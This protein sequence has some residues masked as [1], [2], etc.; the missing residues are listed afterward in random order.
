MTDEIRLRVADVAPRQHI[1][2]P[3][4]EN[5]EVVGNISGVIQVNPNLSTFFIHTGILGFEY[6]EGQFAG[7]DESRLAQV[8]S[9]LPYGVGDRFGVH[10]DGLVQDWG[11]AKPETAVAC[12]VAGFRI[13]RAED[14]TEF[15]QA[16][17]T[18]ARVIMVKQSNLPN[19]P[20][21]ALLKVDI[22]VRGGNFFE[23]TYHVTLKSQD[24]DLRQFNPRD[25]RPEG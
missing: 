23:I 21:A 20:T 22:N 4:I 25:A 11:S 8:T 6:P 2:A 24:P 7:G 14:G 12:S 1:I 3:Y 13:C 9:F 10:L 15:G 17:V 19:D 18:A 16:R 5:I